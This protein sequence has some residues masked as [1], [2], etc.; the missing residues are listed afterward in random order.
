ML[1]L[2]WFWSVVIPFN[3]VVDWPSNTP[4]FFRFIDIVHA[5][6]SPE[7]EF[8]IST[9]STMFK[10]RVP[11]IHLELFTLMKNALKDEEVDWVILWDSSAK[12]EE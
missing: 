2:N 9:R 8:R 12:S 1:S 10:I 3:L 4:E 11:S 7:F 6:L 5:V